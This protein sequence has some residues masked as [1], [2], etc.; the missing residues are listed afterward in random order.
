MIWILQG[1]SS[2]RYRTQDNRRTWLR[3]SQGAQIK[4]LDSV[5][6]RH[7]PTWTAYSHASNSERLVCM[8]VHVKYEGWWRWC[9]K[10]IWRLEGIINDGHFK[11]FKGAHLFSQICNQETVGFNAV[12]RQIS[13]SILQ[14][15]SQIR[16]T[17]C[18]SCQSQ[19]FKNTE[20]F[21]KKKKEYWKI[22]RA[23]LHWQLKVNI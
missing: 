2:T 13:I 8:K 4:T 23:L 10:I 11:Y 22:I 12:H 6:G 9:F 7:L 1:K 16:H 21:K 20:R 19:C 15:L 3:N 14:T 17:H 18:I 5:S